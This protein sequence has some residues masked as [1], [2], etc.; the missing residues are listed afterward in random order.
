M[1]L[2]IGTGVAAFVACSSNTPRPAPPPLPTPSLC[3]VAA[4]TNT[5]AGAVP[6][7]RA[8][9]WARLILRSHS[10]GIV[11]GNVSD[12]TNTP[13]RWV[14]P[15]IRCREPAEQSAPIPQHPIGEDDVV[16][17]RVSNAP[18]FRLVWIMTDRFENGEAV[19]PVALAEFASPNVVVR[20]IGTMRTFPRRARLRFEILGNRRVLVG[21]GEIC[22]DDNNPLTC[23][24]QARLMLLRNNRFAPEPL[25]S[26]SGRCLGPA[27]FEF[28]KEATTTVP[29]T[30]WRRHFALQT[31]LQYRT[32]GIQVHELVTVEDND[33]RRPDVPPTIFRR[34]GQDRAVYVIND[35]F[36]A[37]D[38]SLWSRVLTVEARTGIVRDAGADVRDAADA[39]DESDMDLI[40]GGT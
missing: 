40:D 27:R 19:G 37:S 30:G 20:A 11:P 33:P 5:R 6:T 22:T 12:C 14:D 8:D 1:T 25:R 35:T 21:E 24:R 15:A 32:E 17:S 7:M 26:Q 31:S 3:S 9:A 13:V 28:A 38:P 34:A 36:I 4:P 29:E 18:N 16:V 2:A 23:R 39:D 10:P